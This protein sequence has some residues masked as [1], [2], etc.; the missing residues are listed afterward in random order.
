MSTQWKTPQTTSKCA[1]VGGENKTF[2]LEKDRERG[3]II[4]V[5]SG[6]TKF[7]RHY[8][9]EVTLHPNFERNTIIF[10]KM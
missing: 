5:L 6:D 1:V 9:F 4:S 7:T 3:V 10:F 2:V 8:F